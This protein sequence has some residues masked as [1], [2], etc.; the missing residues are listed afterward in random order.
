MIMIL[1]YLYYFI[2]FHKNLFAWT[3]I[4]LVGSSRIMNLESPKNAIAT[5]NFRFYPPERFLAII[6]FYSVNLIS[7]NIFN[8]YSSHYSYWTFLTAQYTIRFSY[9]VNDPNIVFIYGHTPIIPF[10]LFFRKISLFPN[11]LIVPSVYSNCPE[12]ILI[13]V[14]FPA[15]LCP[16]KENIWFWY[17]SKF[18]ESNANLPLLYFFFKLWTDTTWFWLK[19]YL[20]YFS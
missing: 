6:S 12:R 15:P 11:I 7:F 1:S 5:H 8:T 19:F 4:P 16:K 18:K 3:S 10:N 20:F 2:I 13:V 17:K 9:T 14:D